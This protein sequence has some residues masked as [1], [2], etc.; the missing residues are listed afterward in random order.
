MLWITGLNGL[1]EHVMKA[2]DVKVDYA[3]TFAL[4]LIE[5]SIGVKKP[6]RTATFGRLNNGGIGL[7]GSLMLK[8]SA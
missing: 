6:G 5:I 4:F 2:E 3:E 1:G 8:I 7:Q